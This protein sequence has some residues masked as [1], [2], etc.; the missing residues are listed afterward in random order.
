MDV[1]VTD[2]KDSKIS[3]LTDLLGRS[4]DAIKQRSIKQRRDVLP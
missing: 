3:R 1:M 4:M 2:T